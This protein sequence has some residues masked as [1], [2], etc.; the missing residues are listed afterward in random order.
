MCWVVTLGFRPQPTFQ[1]DWQIVV[2]ASAC[3]RHPKGRA[4]LWCR[5]Q[6][7][8]QHPKGR[9]TMRG[10][11][12]P[13]LLLALFLIGSGCAHRSRPEPQAQLTYVSKP[14]IDFGRGGGGLPLE[15]VKDLHT[16]ADLLLG[17]THG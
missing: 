2:R 10:K 12:S 9:N 8:I 3:I 16:N 13:I 14:V 7:A 17:L 5:L 6:P 4:G 15:G 1:K 11:F